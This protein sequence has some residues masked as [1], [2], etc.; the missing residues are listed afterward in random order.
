MSDESEE[1]KVMKKDHKL[2][3]EEKTLES[4]RENG[5]IDRDYILIESPNGFISHP[6]EQDN[7]TSMNTIGE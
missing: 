3:D 1:V 2:K 5:D 7:D 4:H 6:Y